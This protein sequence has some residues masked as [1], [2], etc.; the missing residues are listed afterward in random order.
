MIDKGQD[1]CKTA[2]CEHVAGFAGM[3]ICQ[4]CYER[5]KNKGMM[6]CNEDE[7]EA[8]TALPSE[9]SGEESSE[10]ESNEESTQ[11]SSER[12][13]LTSATGNSTIYRASTNLVRPYE[14][15]SKA[16]RKRNDS[17]EVAYE[18]RRSEARKRAMERISELQGKAKQIAEK[19]VEREKVVEK[20]R[21]V[22]EEI[23]GRTTKDANNKLTQ[24]IEA[25]TEGNWASGIEPHKVKG[26][27]ER[28]IKLQTADYLDKMVTAILMRAKGLDTAA[29]DP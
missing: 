24:F 11:R 14:V 21:G 16:R 26:Q 27:L 28:I 13:Y 18:N 25:E 20:V 1:R 8:T 4:M 5:E 9:E 22:I 12:T 10:N 29:F 23:S 19:A 3:K 2:G 17:L 15:C 6:I 7:E